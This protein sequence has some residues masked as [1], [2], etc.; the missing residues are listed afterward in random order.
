MTVDAGAEVKVFG[1]EVGVSFF[2]HF[3]V[4]AAKPFLIYAKIRVCGRIKILFAK[5]EICADVEL[6]WEKDRHVDKTPIP[7]IP[8]DIPDKLARAV[9]GIHMLTGQSF[10]LIYLNSKKGKV[11]EDLAL[12]KVNDSRFNT[13]KTAIIPLDT[14][15]DIKLDKSMMQDKNNPV[16][17]GSY[18]NPPENYEDLIPPENK[19]KRNTLRQVI[20]RYQIIDIKIWAAQDGSNK[21]VEYHPYE[22]VVKEGDRDTVDHLPIGHWQKS[23]KEY[24]AIRLLANSPFSYVEQGEPGWFIPEQLGLTPSTLF[25]EGKQ[26]AAKCA[27]WLHSPLNKIYRTA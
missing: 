1:I 20:H 7:P 13:V 15:V 3:S 10:D 16:N 26:R 17:I 8:L 5:I 2:A 27:N 21:W 14:Y 6:K 4:E 23:T 24:N 18:T 9:K 22:A 11:N 19:L 12:P 25:C